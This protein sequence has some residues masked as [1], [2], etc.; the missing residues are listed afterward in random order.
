MKLIEQ[1]TNIKDR[2]DSTIVLIKEAL[3]L[4]G[5]DTPENL[6]YIQVPKYIKQIY[7]SDYEFL[8]NF[9]NIDQF[10]SPHV[11][12][13]GQSTGNMIGINPFY[14]ELNIPE[15]SFETNFEFQNYN[16]YGYG[17]VWK[18]TNPLQPSLPYNSPVNFEQ[19]DEP[20]MP[21]VLNYDPSLS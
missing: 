13:T 16:S 12:N 7:Q 4:K 14:N 20:T 15:Y 6:H 17:H 18:L 9:Q 1:L 5:V 21:E 8:F 3:F 2:L 11:P 19:H 10:G